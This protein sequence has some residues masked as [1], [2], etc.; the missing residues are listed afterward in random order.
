M[1]SELTLRCDNRLSATRSVSFPPAIGLSSE[2]MP[3]TCTLSAALNTSATVWLVARPIAVE[4][5]DALF[6]CQLTQVGSTLVYSGSLS[7]STVAAV[8]H[9]GSEAS[10]EITVELVEVWTASGTTH[11]RTL[12]MFDTTIL[13]SVYG[14]T[15][16]DETI[17][18]ALTAVTDCAAY[19][20]TITGLVAVEQAARIAG[21]EQ[22]YDTISLLTGNVATKMD[23]IVA[24]EGNFVLANDSTGNAKPTT[25]TEGM[26]EA[27]LPSA[28]LAKLISAASSSCRLF[29]GEISNASGYYVR[30][31]GGCGVVKTVSAALEDIPQAVADG[32]ASPVQYVE[33]SETEVLLQDGYNIIFWD[34]SA[35]ALTSCLREDMASVFD[36][37]RD[38]AVGRVYHDATAGTKVFRLCG[39]DGW[40]FPRRVQMFGEERFP[41]ERASGLMI[42]NPSELHISL[43]AG[44]IWAGLVN[45]FPI[46]GFDSSATDTFTTWARDASGGEPGTWVSTS[47]QQQIDAANYN[48]ALAG[49]GLSELT[50]NR[51]GVHWI[52]VVHDSSVHVVYGTGD[53]TLAQAQNATPP[54]ILPGLIAAYATIVGKAIVK[55]NAATLTSIQSPFVTNLGLATVNEHND[56]GEIQGGSAGEYYHLTSAQVTAVNGAVRHDTAQALS[57]AAKVQG[58]NNLLVPTAAG[59]QALTYPQLYR[60]RINSNSLGLYAHQH[61]YYQAATTTNMTVSATIG[62]TSLS[63]YK[64][65]D[66]SIAKAYFPSSFAAGTYPGNIN[67]V[68]SYKHAVSVSFGVSNLTS[69]TLFWGFATATS[70][71]TTLTPV[72]LTLGFEIAPSEGEGLRVRGVV[73]TS[74]NGLQYTNWGLLRKHDGSIPY[75]LNGWLNVAWVSDG[76]GNISWYTADVLIGTL[77]I[78]VNY[79]NSISSGATAAIMDGAAGV[80]E[81]LFLNTTR[82]VVYS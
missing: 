5:G 12:A 22:L 33:W 35:G 4:A 32:Q 81:K 1:A 27:N 28:A 26:L 30:V 38:F 44:V 62:G 70:F 43:T 16:S 46:N 36:F 80:S 48:N 37:T 53:Y 57:E 20:D 25:V 65:A 34:A 52:Y 56:L 47:G 75:L 13:R 11:R 71:T 10:A 24:P 61:F 78:D 41:V 18:Q 39:M 9:L 69:S 14:G 29:G 54:T 77:T 68:F 82:I 19:A 3:V 7:P 49:G 73:W 72:A 8:A 66:G 15:Y 79:S 63:L 21:D 6:A 2:A 50:A 55:K 23:K 74:Q 42:G 45:R 51:Y 31:K 17:A 76:Y 58:A 59:A 67:F 60:L 40:N 64:T